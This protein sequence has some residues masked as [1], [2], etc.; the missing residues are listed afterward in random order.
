VAGNNINLVIGDYD[1]DGN[2]DMAAPN[3]VSVGAINVLHGRGDG[4]FDAATSYAAFSA[5]VYLN[6]STPDR[7]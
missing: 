5:P 7:Q 1:H 4:S 3:T 2:L 6:N